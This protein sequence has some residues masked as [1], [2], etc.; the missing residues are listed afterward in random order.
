MTTQTLPVGATKNRETVTLKNA[1]DEALA[2]KVAWDFRL[3]I[4]EGDLRGALASGY[5]VPQVRR[6]LVAVSVQH[7][8]AV[9]YLGACLDAWL[10]AVDTARHRAAVVAARGRKGLGGVIG[11]G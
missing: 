8:E 7:E 3:E 9:G 1:Y 5:R 6:A 2:I 11:R 10:G 4:A